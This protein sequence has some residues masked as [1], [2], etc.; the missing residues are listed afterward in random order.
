MKKVKVSTVRQLAD[1]E[2]I[3]VNANLISKV[4]NAD[5]AIKEIIINATSQGCIS[6][7]YA[8]VTDENGAT[9]VQPAVDETGKQ[10]IEYSSMHIDSYSVAEIAEKVA[11]ILNELTA[12]FLNEG[13]D[14]KDKK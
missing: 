6:P 11:P 13:D 8:E 14:D 7:K 3:Y 10:I 1:V 2:V 12:A 9:T 5:N 4:I